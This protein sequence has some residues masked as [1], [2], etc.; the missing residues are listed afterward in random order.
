MKGHVQ[1]KLHVHRNSHDELKAESSKILKLYF[2]SAILHK[3]GFFCRT[4]TQK[5][6][7]KLRHYV[8]KIHK[9]VYSKANKIPLMLEIAFKKCY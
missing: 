2:L 6:N 3:A 4:R 5:W 9:D 1:E 7:Y 8:T